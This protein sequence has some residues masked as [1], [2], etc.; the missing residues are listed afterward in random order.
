MRVA[1]LRAHF[2]I[3]KDQA[4]YWRWRVFA[5]NS[6]IIGDS[7]EGYAT[8]SACVHGM[9]LVRAIPESDSFWD[10]EAKQWVHG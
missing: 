9:K 10:A 8:R 1:E 2:E 3:Y 4:G 6:K 5:V 7:A